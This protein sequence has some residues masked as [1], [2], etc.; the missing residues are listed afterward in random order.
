M[1]YKKT[2]KKSKGKIIVP[3]VISVLALLILIPSGIYAVKHNY[4]IAKMLPVNKETKNRAFWLS[5]NEDKFEKLKQSEKIV[6]YHTS[7]N[8]INVAV[9]DD[10]YLYSFLFNRH[11]SDFSHISIRSFDN[12]P[13]NMVRIGFD[14][15]GTTIKSFANFRKDDPTSFRDNYR[16][17]SDEEV[18]QLTKKSLKL[19]NQFI[20]DY[21]NL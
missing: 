17:I 8:N 21:N 10:K 7:S 2:N 3:I 20:K 14:T 4:S 13:G 5:T 6:Y 9:E 11:G 18:N 15:D 16:E 12:T 1:S 19:Y